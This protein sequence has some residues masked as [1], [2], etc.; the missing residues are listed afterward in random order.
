MR[1]HYL[2]NLRWLCTLFLIPYHVLRIFNP[3]ESFYV[4]S[5]EIEAASI[6]LYAVWPWFMPLLFTIAGI[7][8]AYAL[9]R[10]SVREYIRERNAK[11][12]VPLIAG[13]LIVVP[14]QT[15]YAERF[16]NGYTGGYFAQYVLFFT[17]PTDLSGYAGGFTPAHLW[18]L[19]YLLIISFAALPLIVWNKRA[20]RNF[21]AN[22]LSL[23]AGISL[24]LLPILASPILNIAG[25][26]LGEYFVYF[27]L[28]CFV[29]SDE[30]FSKRLQKHRILLSVF[31]LCCIVTTFLL[32]YFDWAVPWPWLDLAIRFYGWLAV[33]ALIGMSRQY[34]NVRTTFTRYMSRSSFAVYIFHQTWIVVVAYYVLQFTKSIPVQ[35][36]SILLGSALATFGTYEICKRNALTRY[37]FA[38]KREQPKAVR[39]P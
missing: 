31:C 15:Y 30:N 6:F 21:T 25:M 7:S 28:G 2:D 27:I 34:L 3:G 36:G 29:L 18:F 24:F 22:N 16:H 14:V 20:K 26:S 13:I 33:L 9:K 39:D 32:L 38:I 5:S 1:K 4:K 17:K 19:L 10:K 12:L 8:T 35:I 23:V 37:L 11:L